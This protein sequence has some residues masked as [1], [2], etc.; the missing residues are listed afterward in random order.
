MALGCIKRTDMDVQ[1]GKGFH[2]QNESRN[3]G[4]V[5]AKCLILEGH[6]HGQRSLR[7]RL[8]N[9]LTP[10][11][12]HFPCKVSCIGKFTNW[13][14]ASCHSFTTRDKTF[15]QS[16]WDSSL[17]ASR[18]I[19]SQVLTGKLVLNFALTTP[20]VPWPRQTLPHTTRYFVPFFSVFAC[21]ERNHGVS[22][23]LEWRR[24]PRHEQIS[25]GHY[26]VTNQAR[27]YLSHLYFETMPQPRI[28]R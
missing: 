2:V 3:L 21:F 22:I 28:L 19:I 24:T 1:R 12:A 20:F 4:E 11:R 5:R 27:C 9:R 6:T 14:Q 16:K 23:T 13:E 8:Y 15:N 17:V 25:Q 10:P 7:S 26:S 18:W